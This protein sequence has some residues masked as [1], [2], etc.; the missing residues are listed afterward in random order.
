VR[1]YNQ[2]NQKVHEV[3][4]MGVYI[5]IRVPKQRRKLDQLLKEHIERM[6]TSLQKTSRTV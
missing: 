4:L 6:G 2:E 1:F 3:T 5:D